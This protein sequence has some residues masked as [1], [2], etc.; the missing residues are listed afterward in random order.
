MTFHPR[1]PQ[2]LVL[3]CAAMW[4]A[5]CRD[6]ERIQLKADVHQLREELRVERSR[7]EA[8][9]ADLA[10]E[11]QA[12]L[13]EPPPE[14]APGC[15][16]ATEGVAPAEA[17]AAAAVAPVRVPAQRGPV[18]ATRVAAALKPYRPSSAVTRAPVPRAT[19]KG[20]ALGFADSEPPLA[21]TQPVREASPALV[22]L[23][24]DALQ[25]LNAASQ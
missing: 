19:V 25:A 18:T 2:L 23:P 3:A 4:L 13:L 1:W 22:P 16:P 11:R 12:G 17:V 5:G 7:V 15:A 21:T 6:D 24:A 14:V 20:A 10:Y 9:Q 8:L